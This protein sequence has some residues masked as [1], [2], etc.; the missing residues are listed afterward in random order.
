MR[1]ARVDLLQHLV[2]LHSVS[3]TRQRREIRL[4]SRQRFESFL[5]TRRFF[6]RPLARRVAS[7]SFYSPRPRRNRLLPHDPER[8]DLACR[9]YVS[10]AAKLHRVASQFFRLTA[11]LHDA[12]GLTVLLSKELLNVF[13]LL[14]LSVRNFRPRHRGALGDFFVHQFFHIALLPRRE[15]CAREVERELIR[16]NVTSLLCGIP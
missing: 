12:H 16:P 10:A 13:A 14:G 11:N 3:E 2:C 7:N 6:T 8:A 1:R 4:L 15:R 9:F 5:L